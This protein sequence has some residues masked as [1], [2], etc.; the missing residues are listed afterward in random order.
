MAECEE[1]LAALDEA[2]AI[3]KRAHRGIFEFGDPADDDD[4]EEKPRGKA[5]GR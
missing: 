3:A 1:V 5:W 4:E 2:E